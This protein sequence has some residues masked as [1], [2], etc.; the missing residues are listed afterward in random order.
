VGVQRVGGDHH[1]DKLQPDQQRLEGGDLTGGAVELALGEHRAGGVVH[2]SEQVDLPAVAA[3]AAQRLAVDCDGPPALA[4]AL[5]V[6]K[7]PSDRSRQRLGIQAGQRPADRGLGRDRPAAGE[8][9]AAGPE[10]GAY[11]LG[12][13]RGPFG[14]RGDRPRTGQDRSSGERQDG[15][16]RVAAPGAGPGVGDRRKVGQQVRCLGWSQRL[17]VAKD[18]QAGWDRG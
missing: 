6:G 8:R 3:G 7:P 9:V 17:S 1:A 13:V 2:R 16:Q 11:R 5:A 15:G 10:R 18:G 4:G 14:D 12:C